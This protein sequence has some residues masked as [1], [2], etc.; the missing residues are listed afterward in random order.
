MQVLQDPTNQYI[1]TILSQCD[2]AGKDVL[3]IGCGK[4]RITRDL[5][6][7][8][9]RVAASDPDA[10]TLEKARAALS[11]A[12]VEFM[13]APTGV[14]DLP[15]ESFDVVIYTLSLHH[16]PVAEM[17]DSLRKAARLLRKN[18]VIM[19]VE[20]GE[21]GSFTETKERFGAGSGDERPAQR[22]AIHAMHALEGWTA[23]ATISFRTL[24]QFEDDDDFLT[25]MLPDYR[26]RP[27]NFIAEVKRFLDQHRAS[28]GIVL[29]SYRRLNLLRRSAAGIQQ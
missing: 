25:N 29:D 12:N 1:A 8:A 24:F 5:A 10:D 28:D 26:K 3:E 19:V 7:H 18:G 17:P 20:P 6:Q 23:G 4:G 13:L 2:L 15:P 27:E 16:V 21:G 9:R 14:P 11:A 22:S